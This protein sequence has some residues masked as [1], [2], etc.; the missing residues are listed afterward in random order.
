MNLK[1]ELK[2]KR[3]PRMNQRTSVFMLTSSN[4]GPY[5][6]LRGLGHFCTER[7]RAWTSQCM[8]VTDTS[9]YD[10][11][12][13]GYFYVT[14]FFLIIYATKC[15]C[16]IC[17]C[18][19]STKARSF[20]C[21]FFFFSFHLTRTNIFGLIFGKFSLQFYPFFYF[22]FFGSS[23]SCIINRRPKMGQNL[24]KLYRT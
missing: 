11:F 7:F 9:V 20:I 5:T 4:E 1:Y 18:Y 13:W 14:S 15:L 23:S 22:F 8:D 6:I 3:E 12:V 2:L 19:F 16:L 17:M 21:I 10:C 24:H